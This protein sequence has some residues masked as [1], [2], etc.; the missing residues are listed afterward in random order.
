M[1]YGTIEMFSILLVY[2]EDYYA[3]IAKF[4]CLVTKHRQFV[5][6]IQKKN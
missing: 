4:K 6:Y 3:A 1:F 2:R 5:P